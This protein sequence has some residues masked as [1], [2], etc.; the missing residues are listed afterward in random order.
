[1]RVMSNTPAAV[2]LVNDNFVLKGHVDYSPKDA[3]CVRI[4]RLPPTA[5]HRVYEV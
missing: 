5:P 1:M 3:F 2:G 4:F